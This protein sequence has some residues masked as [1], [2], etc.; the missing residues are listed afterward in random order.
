M[1]AISA[2]GPKEL[3]LYNVICNK[4]VGTMSCISNSIRRI[5]RN[6]IPIK[7]YSMGFPCT[8]IMH[9]SQSHILVSRSVPIKSLAD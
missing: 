3:I 8:D 2:I 9:D 6:C 1:M 4:F 5:G 7:L